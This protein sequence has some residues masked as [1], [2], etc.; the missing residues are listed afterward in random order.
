M[1]DRAGKLSALSP[2]SAVGGNSQQFPFPVRDQPQRILRC[3]RVQTA[4]REIPRRIKSL[5]RNGVR[6]ASWVCSS[7]SMP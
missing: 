7:A 6:R 2:D 4:A 5:S 1:V 3:W